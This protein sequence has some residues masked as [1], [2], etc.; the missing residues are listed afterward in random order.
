[1][2]VRE[3]VTNLYTVPVTV[4]TSE[5]QR[6]VVIPLEKHSYY[7]TSEIASSCLLAMTVREK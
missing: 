4:I 1:M 3:K 5:V 6:R 2:T 7:A